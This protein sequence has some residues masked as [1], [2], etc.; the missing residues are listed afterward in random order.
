MYYKAFLISQLCF[1]FLIS[2]NLL[3]WGKI[4]WRA[5]ML[6]ILLIIILTSYNPMIKTD[7]FTWEE[8]GVQVENFYANG[9]P[10]LIIIN[11]MEF[12]P[13]VFPILKIKSSSH[14]IRLT[15]TQHFYSRISC[16]STNWWRKALSKTK[17]TLSIFS[18]GGIFLPLPYWILRRCIYGKYKRACIVIDD[19]SFNF[20]PTLVPVVDW[21]NNSSFSSYFTT[22]CPLL[23][24]V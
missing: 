19:T 13:L 20:L 16:L 5:E 10:I 24:V 21:N 3:E 22:C 9:R 14:L 11:H 4:W 17:S 6:C 23:F 12:Q 7:T 18:Q 8:S 15:T 2:W 1:L